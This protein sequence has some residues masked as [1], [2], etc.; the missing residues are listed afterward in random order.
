V[1][2]DIGDIQECIR[3]SQDAARAK[4]GVP[5]D[6]MKA[7]YRWACC[8]LLLES[9]TPTSMLEPFGIAISMLP[10]MSS[11]GSSLADRHY[12][13]QAAGFVARQAAAAA[14][15][16][17]ESSLAAEWLEQGRSIIWGQ[18]LRL[19]APLDD[20]RKSYPEYAQRLQLNSF[21][22][23]N[24]SSPSHVR[25]A[26]E[27]EAHLQ[28]AAKSLEYIAQQGHQ[29]AQQREGLLAEIRRLP[30]FERSIIE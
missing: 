10:E 18:L 14:I 23:E 27:G 13:I 21:N 19:R 3:K 20:L 8:L 30:G 11:L 22:L 28:P 7:A 25:L 6:R 12:S 5:S 2:S 24:A 16:A 15:R 4:Y 17:E 26:Q 29:L 1:F 9:S